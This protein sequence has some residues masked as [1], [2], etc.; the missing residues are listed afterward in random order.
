MGRRLLRTEYV[1]HKDENRFNELRVNLQLLFPSKHQSL[2][3][4]GKSLTVEHKEKIG[5]ANSRRRGMKLKKHVNIPLDIMANLK[6][7]GMT[8]NGISN[9]FGVDWST[10]KSRF[11]ENPEL[12]EVEQ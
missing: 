11:L 8:I 3:N 10:I 6:S 2:H 5:I 12:L 1:H 7:Q 9:F 4:K